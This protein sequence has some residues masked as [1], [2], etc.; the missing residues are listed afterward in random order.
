MEAYVHI[1]S[2]FL[3]ERTSV[4]DLPV[5]TSRFWSQVFHWFR[6]CPCFCG[7]NRKLGGN[8]GNIGTHTLQA[9]SMPPYWSNTPVICVTSHQETS[10][11]S[12]STLGT[13]QTHGVT[14]E[15]PG[16]VCV[17]VVE[18][19]AETSTSSA[20]QAHGA[21][22]FNGDASTTTLKMQQLI[23]R[24]TVPLAPS[25]ATLGKPTT[26]L[27]PNHVHAVLQL[28]PLPHITAVA[29]IPVTDPRPQDRS[30]II[31]LKQNADSVFSQAEHCPP[32]NPLPRPPLLLSNNPFL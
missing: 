1:Q 15:D 22:P 27:P 8:S 13:G 32:P 25:A 14:W 28:F 19:T 2:L 9:E 6:E 31:S 10:L 11:S 23:E 17:C 4:R 7:L 5:W 24:I 12:S 21:S 30:E 29:P 26:Q 3:F 18:I 16:C 20:P